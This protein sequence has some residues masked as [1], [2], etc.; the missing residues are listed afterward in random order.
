MNTN[1][2]RHRPKQLPTSQVPL[3]K[4][5]IGHSRSRSDLHRVPEPPQRFADVALRKNLGIICL[6][7]NKGNALK[8]I[9]LRPN[10]LEQD[11]QQE[12]FP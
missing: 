6:I 3:G 10:E 11:E 5:L 2:P 1:R 9:F 4:R 7:R 8:I 12:V